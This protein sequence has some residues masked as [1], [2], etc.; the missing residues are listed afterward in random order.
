MLASSVPITITVSIVTFSLKSNLILSF[1]KF[2][3][4]N[5]RNSKISCG[6]KGH[7]TK[8]EICETGVCLASLAFSNPLPQPLDSKAWS[9]EVM[10]EP[11]T[12]GPVVTRKQT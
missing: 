3:N 7:L 5:E 4:V 6:I 8:L 1:L 10:N 2:N 9:L 12:T 11:C